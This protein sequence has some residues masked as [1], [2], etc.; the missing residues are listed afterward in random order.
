MLEHLRAAAVVV[1][2]GTGLQRAGLAA[3]RIS[4]DGRVPAGPATDS[5]RG[6]VSGADFGPAVA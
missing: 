2:A 6:R 3:H 1:A 4:P 5:A